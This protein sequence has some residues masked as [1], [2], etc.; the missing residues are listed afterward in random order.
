MAAEQ[1]FGPPGLGT[2]V[3][4]MSS[5]LMDILAGI[6][7]LAKIEAEVET[8]AKNLEKYIKASATTCR[9][10]FQVIGKIMEQEPL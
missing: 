10:L 6:E 1:S 3:G 7:Q 5:R 4:E 2:S 9:N 8:D